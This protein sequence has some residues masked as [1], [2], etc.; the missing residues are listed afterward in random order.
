M[1]PRDEKE[2]AAAGLVRMNI[3]NTFNHRRG[4]R[5][6]SF[7]FFMANLKALKINKKSIKVYGFAKELIKPIERV[8][9]Q[10]RVITPTERER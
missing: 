5:K 1:R 7:S 9:E 6:I 4:G 8:S 2:A 3:F 10:S